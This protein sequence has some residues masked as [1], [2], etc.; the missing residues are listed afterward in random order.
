MIGTLQFMSPEHTNGQEQTPAADVFSLGLIAAVAATGSDIRTATPGPSRWPRR[1]PT[2]K[3]RP[4]DLT[5]YPEP[6]RARSLSA[7]WPPTPPLARP[8]RTGRPVP[9]VGR[10]PVAGLHRLAACAGRGGHRTA[11]ATCA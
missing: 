5:S 1:S 3:F 10:A 8:F 2:P 7:P 4:P 6:L 11:G 9:G